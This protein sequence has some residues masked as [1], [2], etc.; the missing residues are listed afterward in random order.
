MAKKKKK[1]ALRVSLADLKHKR[2]ELGEEIRKLEDLQWEVAWQIAQRECP[3]KIGQILSR[4]RFNRRY[5]VT[6]IA[7]LT[8]A[9][10]KQVVTWALRI[11]VIN[12]DG[13]RRRRSRPEMIW[14]R[15]FKEDYVVEDATP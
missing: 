8:V 14:P 5:V 7:S 9:A 1:S 3:V 10:E 2:D 6:T 4:P 12:K 11:A 13:R 15:V